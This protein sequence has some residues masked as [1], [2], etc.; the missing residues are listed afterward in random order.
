[1]E[2][3]DGIDGTG[4]GGAGIYADRNSQVIVSAGIT[5]PTLTGTVGDI[6][7]DETTEVITWADIMEGSELRLVN[8]ATVILE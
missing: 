2:L 7:V 8:K 5:T 4:N 3:Q 6:S 1:L